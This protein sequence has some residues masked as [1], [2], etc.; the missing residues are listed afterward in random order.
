MAQQPLDRIRRIGMLLNYSKDDPEDALLRKVFWES[1]KQLGWIDGRNI[2]TEYR[3]YGGDSTR[4]QVMAKELVELQPDLIVAAATPGLSATASQTHAIPIVFVAVSDPVGQGFVENLAR[5]GGNATGLTFFEFTV[6]S[7]M[8]ET[9]KEIAPALTRVALLFNPDNPAVYPF[10]PVLDAAAQQRGLEL[11]RKPI[12]NSGEIEVAI[13][14]AARQPD[15]G[16]L[17]VPDPFTNTN[18]ELIASL[19]ARYR[20]PAISSL[21]AY[22]KAGGLVAYGPDITDLYRRAATYVDHILKGA[23]PA[24]LPV[25]QPTKFELVINIKTAKSLGLTVP[26]VMQMT[27][28]EAI[29]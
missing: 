11:I 6:A 18:R 1:M 9:L 4:V 21:S 7:K 29:E 12:R 19:A 26:L 20:L 23:K 25:E 22:A 2:S 27:A 3:W 8:L 24:D 10:L 5:P 17:L 28:D 15:S 16:L 13:G 14:E